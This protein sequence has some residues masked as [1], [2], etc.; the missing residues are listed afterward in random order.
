MGHDTIKS[1]HSGGTPLGRHRRI[2]MVMAVALTLTFTGFLVLLAILLYR[3]AMAGG[4][5]V[6]VIAADTLF[7]VSTL[8]LSPIM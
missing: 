6:A 1:K 5:S 3:I 2:I 7:L 8:I 4:S